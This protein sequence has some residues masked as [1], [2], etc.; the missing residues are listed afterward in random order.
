MKSYTKLIILLL[1]V[2]V[3]FNILSPLTRIQNIFFGFVFIALGIFG[4]IYRKKRGREL[5]KSHA[6]F[7][8]V[9]KLEKD[10]LFN[11]YFIDLLAFLSFTWIVLGVL[12]ILGILK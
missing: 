5:A 12:L 3:I 7:Y 10:K 2:A 1:S 11:E 6:K 8:R 4:F 9:K